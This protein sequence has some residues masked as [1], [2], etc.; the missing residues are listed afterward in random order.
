MLGCIDSIYHTPEWKTTD[1]PA[2]GAEH[3]AG[4]DPGRSSVLVLYSPPITILF[5]CVVPHGCVIK[6][7]HSVIEPDSR[8]IL[9][10]AG[11]SLQYIG[12]ERE[13]RYAGGSDVAGNI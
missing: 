4:E 5:H 12:C 10:C 3:D 7:L 2:S 9:L 8:V 13:N 6:F 1:E 11:S